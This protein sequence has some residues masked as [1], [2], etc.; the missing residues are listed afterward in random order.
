MDN[1]SVF[2]FQILAILTIENWFLKTIA[3]ILCI[4]LVWKKKREVISNKKQVFEQA[5]YWVG[6]LF[7]NCMINIDVQ[8]INFV[9]FCFGS[10]LVQKINI[11]IDKYCSLY[12]LLFLIS[13]VSTLW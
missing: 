10:I 1:N 8:F 2:V 7:L 13:G 9:Y 6:V 3:I 11:K 12:L 5:V 4:L